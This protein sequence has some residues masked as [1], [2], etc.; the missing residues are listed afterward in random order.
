MDGRRL[1]RLGPPGPRAVE[2]TVPKDDAVEAGVRRRQSFEV[3]DGLAGSRDPGGGGGRDGGVLGMR[4]RA[5]GR[6]RDA[7][8]DQPPGTDVRRRGHDVPDADLADMRVRLELL[9][10]DLLARVRREVGHLVDDD[11]GTRLPHRVE[12]RSR[13]EDVDDGRGR[14]GSLDRVGASR[15]PAAA[16]DVVTSGDEHAGERTP[17]GAARTGD[18]DPCHPT[19][20]VAGVISWSDSISSL[21]VGTSSI[22]DAASSAVCEIASWTWPAAS[23]TLPRAL[24]TPS[25]IAAIASSGS[26][27]TAKPPPM[28]VPAIVNVGASAAYPF[29]ART[30]WIPPSPLTAVTTRHSAGTSTWPPP[31]TTLTLSVAPSGARVASRRSRTPPPYHSSS[32]P[33]RRFVAVL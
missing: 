21:S 23:S 15:R 27:W 11:V 10:R 4:V 12:D 25:R 3:D 28:R 26:D 13:V 32:V 2:P 20:Q 31:N 18:E 17:D 7:L 16:R 9:I 14:A 30:S 1:V 19:R 5:D 22:V 8:G 24:A 29:A 33:P 6:P